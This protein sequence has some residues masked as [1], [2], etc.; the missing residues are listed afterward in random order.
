MK[1][2]LALD[3]QRLKSRAY[4]RAE[5]AEGALRRYHSARAELKDAVEPELALLYEWMFVPPTLWPFNI[6]D[7]LE[8]CLASVEKGK[9]LDSRQRL[10]ADLLPAPPDE[11]ICTAVAEH[12][13]H[14]QSGLY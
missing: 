8:D 7:V 9:R 10:L 11:R 1:S 6:Q 14:V 12:E 5:W 2:R 4:S 3:L 13:F